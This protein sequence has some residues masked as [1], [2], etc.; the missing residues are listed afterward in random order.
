MYQSKIKVEDDQLRDPSRS[1]YPIRTDDRPKRVIDHE[2][3][4]IQNRYQP[5]GANQKG[6]GPRTTLQGAEGEANKGP[7]AEA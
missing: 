6:N 1:V 2:S 4:L 7:I 3:R 5:Y